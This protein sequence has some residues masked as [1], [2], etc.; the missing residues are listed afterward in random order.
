VE[1]ETKT[2]VSH[3]CSKELIGEAHA[4]WQEN[5]SKT[6]AIDDPDWG[7]IKKR[8][9][10]PIPRVDLFELLVVWEAQQN[11][12][13]ELLAALRLGRIPAK[14]RNFITYHN[15]QVVKIDGPKP[16]EL[17]VSV[18]RNMVN[19]GDQCASKV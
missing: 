15:L 17:I 14:L 1:A 3:S 9:E 5:S 19:S 16:I 7:E 6:I 11:A 13:K 8:M 12:C 2:I 10:K 4:S 18:K